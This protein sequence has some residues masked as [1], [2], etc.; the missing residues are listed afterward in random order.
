[1]HG[2]TLKFGNT[3]NDFNSEGNVVLTS[4]SVVSSLPMTETHVSRNK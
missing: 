1:M 4:I 3:V 2:E